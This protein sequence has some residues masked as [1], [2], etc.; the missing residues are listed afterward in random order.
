M[1][2]SYGRGFARK[3]AYTKKCSC[4]NPKWHKSHVEVNGLTDEITYVLSCSNCKAYW[5]T[6]SHEARKY[7]DMDEK[8]IAFY[9]FGGS[10]RSELTNR[11]HFRALDRKRLEYLEGCANRR[12]EAV[13]QAR[14]EA[15]KAHR[16]VEKYKAMMEDAE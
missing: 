10:H 11:D 8:P 2:A 1:S 9:G 14:K 15:E 13:L 3:A 7:W 16:A 12:D 5:P 4:E 6:K